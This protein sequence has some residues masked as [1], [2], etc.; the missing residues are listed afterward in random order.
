MLPVFINHRDEL[1]S[2][3]WLWSDNKCN[4]GG[5]SMVF[6]KQSRAGSWELGLHKLVPSRSIAKRTSEERQARAMMAWLWR[7]P[8]ARLRS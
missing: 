6:V 7:S 3:C 4:S 8:S 2:N 5:A 1:V